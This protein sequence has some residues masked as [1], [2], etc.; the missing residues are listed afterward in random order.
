M[1]KALP[2]FVRAAVSPGAF[3][4]SQGWMPASMVRNLLVGEMRSRLA[5]MVEAA[6]KTDALAKVAVPETFRFTAFTVP[7][8]LGLSKG[9]FVSI[10]ACVPAPIIAGV[11]LDVV[12]FMLAFGGHDGNSVPP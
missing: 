5:L 10:S 7:E 11:M 3:I 8:K 9:A 4:I 1:R 12:G 6:L 2:V